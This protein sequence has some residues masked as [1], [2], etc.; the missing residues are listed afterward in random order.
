MPSRTHGAV[1]LNAG[2]KLQVKPQSVGPPPASPALTP[3]SVVQCTDVADVLVSRGSGEPPQDCE[4][5]VIWLLGSSKRVMRGPRPPAGFTTTAA[6][7]MLPAR[8]RAFQLSVYRTRR[9]SSGFT[10]GGAPA[11]GAAAG[12]AFAG[13]VAAMPSFGSSNVQ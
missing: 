6:C 12:Q 2:P 13:G 1:V 8:L 3:S 7:V 5:P 11:I 4:S 10:S 9:K